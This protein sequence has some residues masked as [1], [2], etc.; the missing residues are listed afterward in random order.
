[1]ALYTATQLVA[2][3]SHGREANTAP[4]NFNP[5]THP[6]LATHFFDVEPPR[7]VAEVTS[8]LRRQRQIE[9][10]HRLGDRAV[11]ELLHEVDAG[12]D[13]DSA[14]AAYER[15]TPDLL[16]AVGGDHFP[17]LPISEVR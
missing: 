17:A 9:H 3:V 10:V 12:A 14:L 4:S 7:P 13:L 8:S 16:K 6:I 11:G 1:M 15:L 2:T 5:V